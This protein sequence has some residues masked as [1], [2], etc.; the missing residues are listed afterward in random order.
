MVYCV[1]GEERFS[2]A[3]GSVVSIASGGGS[4]GAAAVREN[5][6]G[7]A[8]R[9]RAGPRV[10]PRKSPGRTKTGSTL[11]GFGKRHRVGDR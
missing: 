6:A 4:F 8:L 11:V 3:V 7:S 10:R 2:G 1:H 5:H 9:E